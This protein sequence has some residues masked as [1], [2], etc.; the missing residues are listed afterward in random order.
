M[1]A[2]R[3]AFFAAAL[4]ALGV[5]AAAARA[6]TP[7]ASPEQPALSPGMPMAMPTAM[8]GPP[9]MDNRIFAHALLEQFEARLGGSGADFRWDGQA[10]AG[11]DYDKLWV[12]TEG[13]VRH[14]GTVD[15]G[16]QEFLYD[17]AITSFF[18][19]QAGLRSDLDS[20]T[21]RQWAAFGIQGLAPYFFDVEATAYASNRGHFAARLKGSYDLLITQRLI[22]QPEIELNLYSKSDPGRL[23]GGGLSDIDTGLRLRYEFSRKFAPYVGVAYEGKF[24]QTASLAR[25]A[26]GGTGGVRFVAGVRMWF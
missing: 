10:W 14:D 22:L 21:G 8:M 26:G 20:G 23:I 5:V 24:G 18:D 25:R 1:S 19:L 2:C 12:K 3:T 7:P 11:T 17:R 6:Q 9:V 4:V 13:F 16:Q 15:D